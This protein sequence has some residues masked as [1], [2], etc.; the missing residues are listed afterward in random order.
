MQATV[1]ASEDAVVEAIDESFEDVAVVELHLGSTNS[2]NN[3][4]KVRNRCK[5][6]KKT[7]SL[8]Y[9]YPNKKITH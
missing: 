8:K 1:V 6:H 4:T 5:I 3:N 9:F 2:N 7:L